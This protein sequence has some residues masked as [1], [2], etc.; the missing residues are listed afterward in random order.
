MNSYHKDLPQRLKNRGNITFSDWI[1]WIEDGHEDQHWKGPYYKHC[2][3]CLV[4]Y[5]RIVKLET[6]DSDSD[7]I[8]NK[9]MS[10]RGY[11]TARNQKDGHKNIMLNSK[12]KRLDRFG[13]CTD[14]QMEFL[15]KRL[16]VDLDMFGYTF[17]EDTFVAKCGYG[18]KCC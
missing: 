13:N 16:R 5:N 11:G 12:G 1:H 2:H 15:S 7:F 9:K 14:S 18:D 17:D 10:G 3:P 4:H 8:I 6:Q